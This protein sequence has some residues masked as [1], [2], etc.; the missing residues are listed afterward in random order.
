[1]QE[2][3]KKEQIWTVNERDARIKRFEEYK[4]LEDWVTRWIELILIFTDRCKS[5]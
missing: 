1:V 5:K 4:G 3:R 2:K